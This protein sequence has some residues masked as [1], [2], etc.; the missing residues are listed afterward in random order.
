MVETFFKRFQLDIRHPVWLRSNTGYLPA[1]SQSCG[2]KHLRPVLRQ[3]PTAGLAG[4]ITILSVV[5]MEKVE[6]RARLPSS[7]VDAE[8]W[9][10]PRCHGFMYLVER[11]TVVLQVFFTERKKEYRLDS[12]WLFDQ[13]GLYRMLYRTL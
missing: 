4:F 6:R 1:F 5:G 2:I 8:L 12:S 13:S 3:L 7:R 11:M 9:K 10:R